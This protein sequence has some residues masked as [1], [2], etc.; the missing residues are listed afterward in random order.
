MTIISNTTMARHK[1]SLS[2]TL[3]GTSTLASQTFILDAGAHTLKAGFSLPNPSIT[4]DCHTIPNCL[5][6]SDRDRR[7]YIA[8]DLAQCQDFGELA[9]RRPVEKGYI[10]N[11]EGEKAVWEHIFADLKVDA[12]ETNL[13]LTEQPGAP[14]ALERWSDEMVFE[15]FGFAAYYRTVRLIIRA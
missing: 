5:A 12:G 13:I 8:A 6:R 10:V 14:A 1:P 15:E 7:T 2:N 11:W 4:R 9:V 3:S